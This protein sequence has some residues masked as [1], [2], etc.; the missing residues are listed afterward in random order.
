[1]EG[2]VAVRDAA[3]AI[4]LSEQEAV[5]CVTNAYGCNGGWMEYAWDYWI[6]NGAMTNADYPYRAYD[7]SCMHDSNS[8]N[9]TYATAHGQITTS[10]TDVV[11]QL[12]N[13]PMTIAVA[14]G[15][16]CWRYYGG[17]ILSSSDGCPTGLDHAVTLVA[18]T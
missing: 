18:Y 9:L 11:L 15:N 16:T 10:I 7:Q 3:V 5:D 12:Q 2:M 1:M 14:A 13:G 4:R 6:A 17:G 8:S